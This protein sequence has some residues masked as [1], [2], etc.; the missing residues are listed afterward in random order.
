[1]RQTGFTILIL[2]LLSGLLEARYSSGPR[3]LT[4]QGNATYGYYCVH[5]YIGPKMQK[6]CLIID[7]GSSSTII[8]CSGCK[9]YGRNHF[10]EMYRTE[11]SPFFTA[12]IN[13]VPELNWKCSSP[14]SNSECPFEKVSSQFNSEL[15]RGQF[16]LRQLRGRPDD[17]SRR[18][19]RH[20]GRQV[21]R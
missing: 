20:A 10:N 4:L 1:M 12:N 16:I 2:M 17:V 3:T 9:E 18:V 19:G 14:N 15:C 6:E 13:S 5:L 11:S 8:P 7:S 21:R